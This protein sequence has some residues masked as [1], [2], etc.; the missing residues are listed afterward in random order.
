MK[1]FVRFIRRTPRTPLPPKPYVDTA[2]TGKH[3]VD[4]RLYDPN[5]LRHVD[6]E[7][8]HWQDSRFESREKV[9]FFDVFGYNRDWSWTIFKVSGLFFVAIFYWETRTLIYMKDD[10][11]KISSTT[12]VSPVPDYARDEHATEEELRA[13]G[14]AYVGVKKLDN[15]GIPSPDLSDGVRK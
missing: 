7:R 8:P 12:N 6:P 15:L 9:P 2:S 4:P 1:W 13:A 3:M 5:D 14:F 10:P 11:L